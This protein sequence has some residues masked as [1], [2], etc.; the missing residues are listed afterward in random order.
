M[1]QY[2][3]STLNS[4]EIYDNVKEMLG[5]LGVILI[6]WYCEYFLKDLYLSRDIH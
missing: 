5:F 4:H 1:K 6:S 3:Q 2:N